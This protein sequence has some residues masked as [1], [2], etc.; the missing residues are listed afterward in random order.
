MKSFVFTNELSSYRAIKLS[1]GF[2]LLEIL[3]VIAILSILGVAGVGYYLN[4]VKSV[5]VKNF[6]QGLV[7]DLKY[8]RGRSMGGESSL[9]WGAHV[10]NS[11]TDYY[12]IFSTPTNYSDSAKSVFSTTTLPQ[13]LSFTDPASGASKDIIFSRIS[14]TTTSATIAVISDGR[15]STTTVS[16]LG[17][18]Y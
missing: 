12:E 2:S 1:K 5:G 15:Y 17:L 9:K 18:V 10:V 14:G 3:L 8:A 11:T 13:G 6:S 4:F 7:S 16:S